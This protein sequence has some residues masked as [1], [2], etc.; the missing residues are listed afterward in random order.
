MIS[1]QHSHAVNGPGNTH[2]VWWY[3]LVGI[4]AV[5]IGLLPWLVT[6]LRLPLQNL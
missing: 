4:G 5:A 3:L 2:R 1:T 6:G